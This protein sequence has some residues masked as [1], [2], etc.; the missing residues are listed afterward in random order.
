[1]LKKGGASGE[2]GG[3]SEHGKYATANHPSDP[4]GDNFGKA[5]LPSSWHVRFISSFPGV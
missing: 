2:L 1:M 5:D 4:D 3:K